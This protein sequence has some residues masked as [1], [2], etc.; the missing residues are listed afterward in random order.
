M[1]HSSAVRKVFC[2]CGR[3]KYPIEK[4]QRVVTN[5]SYI[6]EHQHRR[7]RLLLCTKKALGRSKYDKI[8]VKVTETLVTKG[9]C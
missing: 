3:L 8:G 6:S 4:W 7:E 9:N 2:H 5:I 1:K